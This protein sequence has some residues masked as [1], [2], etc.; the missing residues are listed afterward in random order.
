M[1]INKKNKFALI[2]SDASFSIKDNIAIISF[3]DINKN[4]KKTKRIKVNNIL[5]AEK[6]AI[7]FSLKYALSFYRNIVV[8]SDNLYAVLDIKKNVLR[9]K[10]VTPF[11]FFNYIDVVWVPR[12][13][14][15]AD[16]F[17]KFL[18]EEFLLET[19][20]EKVKIIKNKEKCYK[21]LYEELDLILSKKKEKK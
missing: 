18:D 21:N 8:F 5:E 12:E 1:N 4:I 9:K 6:E 7:F 20:M 17:T 2:F 10:N 14:N 13:Y 15:L 19:L 16:F 11:R 3:V